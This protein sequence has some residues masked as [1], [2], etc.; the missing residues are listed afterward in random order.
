MTSTG[1]CR[2]GSLICHRPGARSPG[3]RWGV[4][5]VRQAEPDDRA[6]V[7]N[8]VAAAFAGD[9]AW[10]F[11]LEDAYG[12]LAPAFAGALF[13][14]RVHSGGVWVSDDLAAVAMWERVDGEKAVG[15]EQ[16]WEAY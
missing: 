3:L 8:T 1:P 4:P 15:A 12:R 7:V 16:I 13:D 2:Y 5:G 14:T 11:L 9:P 10:S 6:A